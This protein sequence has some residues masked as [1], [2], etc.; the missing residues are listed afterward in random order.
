[1]STDRSATVLSTVK[2]SVSEVT[3]RTILDGVLVVELEGALIEAYELAVA[4]RIASRDVEFGSVS[5]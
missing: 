5:H 1:M 4:P 3:R 2:F